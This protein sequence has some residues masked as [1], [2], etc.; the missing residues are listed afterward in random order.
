MQTSE[1]SG[2]SKAS[3]ATTKI[4]ATVMREGQV[5]QGLQLLR[6]LFPPSILPASDSPPPSSLWSLTPE[7][8]NW[9]RRWNIERFMRAGWTL[10]D[11]GKLWKNGNAAAVSH[12][13]PMR[14]RGEK[15]WNPR[16]DTIAARMGCEYIE[17]GRWKGYFLHMG[18]V[19]ASDGRPVDPRLCSGCQGHPFRVRA[20]TPA[21]AQPWE[22]AFTYCRKCVTKEFWEEN[23]RRVN[24]FVPPR[25]PQ[26]QWR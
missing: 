6:S 9:I 4:E 8:R 16:T 2:T 13:V 26:R 23:E 19:C 22:Q 17:E 11:E 14:I 25:Q 12:R 3:V 21:S 1:P 7:Q 24:S 5:Q 18:M 10:G 20:E 15:G